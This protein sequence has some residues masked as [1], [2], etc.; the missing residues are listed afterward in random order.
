[1]KLFL[2]N[3]KSMNSTELTEYMGKKIGDMRIKENMELNLIIRRLA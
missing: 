2:V 3:K 1:M